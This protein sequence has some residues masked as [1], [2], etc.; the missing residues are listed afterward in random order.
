M[1][2]TEQFAT[3]LFRGLGRTHLILQQEDSS[4]YHDG[5][6]EGM[7]YFIQMSGVPGSG[8]STLASALAPQLRAVVIDHDITK[9]ALLEADV[10]VNIAGSASYVVLHYLA[11]SL[12]RQGHSVVFDSPCLYAELL[13]R[14][15]QLATDFGAA[16]RYIECVVD[17]LDEIDR[18]LQQRPR[19][20]S[21]LSGVRAPPTPGSGKTM[22]DERVFRD[23]MANMKRPASGYLEIDTTQPLESYLPTAREYIAT[24][25]GNR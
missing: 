22:I 3:C 13:A 1:M 24:G 23:W 25:R 2:K 12:L 6:S 18:R 17:D 5:D 11:E 10:P 20:P 7:L 14:G 9:S 4:L 8:K 15:Q 19:L 16:Y 21:Q